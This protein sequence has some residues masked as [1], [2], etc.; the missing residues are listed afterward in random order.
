M[1]ME[2]LRQQMAGRSA[3]VARA[4]Q[5]HSDT[6]LQQYSR[7]QGTAAKWAAVNR[8]L[9]TNPD[10][11]V[12]RDQRLIWC[13]VPKVASTALVHGLMRVLGRSD[14]IES[15]ARGHLHMSIRNMMPH[16]SP[17]EDLSAFTAFMA[18]RH[19]FQRILSAYRDKLMNRWEKFQFNKFQNEYAK[20]IIREYRRHPQ[21]KQYEDVPTFGEFVD[22]LIAT[23]VWKYN[24]HWLPYYL[25]CTP[26]HYRYDIIM[27]LDSLSQD[28]KYLAH[29]TGLHELLP[30]LIHATVNTSHTHSKRGKN[31]GKLQSTDDQAQFLTDYQVQFLER[32]IQSGGTEA[33]TESKFFSE[34]SMQQLMKLHSV[35]RIDFDMFKFDISPYDSYVT[36]H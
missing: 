17:H 4:C 34:L 35:Y 13:K 32:S 6:L 15:Q 21:S 18:V 20:A 10:L 27:H 12:N 9:V 3:R 36:H 24:E 14:L 5:R 29:V 1:D 26:C 11:L 28:G 30:R 25:T 2:V 22:Y 19:P 31:A 33:S 7:W 16:P 23:P 8:S